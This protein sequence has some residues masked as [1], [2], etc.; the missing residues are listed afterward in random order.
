MFT[1]LTAGAKQYSHLRQNFGRG[2][3]KIMDL[4]V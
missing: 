1:A 2:L 4:K 3:P